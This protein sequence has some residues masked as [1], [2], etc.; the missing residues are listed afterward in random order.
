MLT[1]DGWIDEVDQQTRAGNNLGL[2]VLLGLA[3]VRCDR[4]REL[5]PGWRLAALGRLRT[6]ALLGATREQLRRMALWEAG[7]VGAAALLAGGAVTALV[8]WTICSATSA[9]VGSS[10]SRR[11]ALPLAA[12]VATGA[13]LT[14]VVALVGGGRGGGG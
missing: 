6:V 13:A 11:R 3:A 2:W 10:R 12:I 8:G 4:D 1:A 5:G 9:D 14:L 7:L